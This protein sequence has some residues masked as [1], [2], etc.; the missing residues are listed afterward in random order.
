MAEGEKISEE[1]AVARPQYASFTLSL[2]QLL[3]SLLNGEGI[4]FFTIEPRTKSLESLNEKINRED[5][6]GKYSALSD[7]TDLSGIRIISYLGKDCVNICKTI[8]E[9]FDIDYINSIKKEDELDPDKFGYLSTHYVLSLKANRLSLPEFSNF[10]ALK[11]EVQVRTLLQHTWAA[12][13]WKFRYKGKS[14]APKEIQRRL[15]RI[16]ALLEAADNEFSAVSHQLDQIRKGYAAEISGGDLK[17]PINLESINSFIIQSPLAKKIILSA[18]KNKIRKPENDSPS[19]GY[20]KLYS[21]L[22]ILEISTIGELAD[23]L[24]KIKNYD[25]FF[26]DLYKNSMTEIGKSD[27]PLVDLAT[28]R[29]ALYYLAKPNLRQLIQQ[30]A[31]LSKGYPLAINK[32]D[33]SHRTKM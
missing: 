1:Y 2:E 11:A 21:T 20:E 13:D 17:I 22:Q 6:E 7:I 18:R 25:A 9:N 23:E 8:E 15:F 32:M 26:A 24:T 10:K 30:R 19:S 4:D 5:K 31:S 12:I 16:S 3:T 14:D 28:I 33:S 27:L 29:Y